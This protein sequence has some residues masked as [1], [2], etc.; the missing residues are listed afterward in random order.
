MTTSPT[1]VVGSPVNSEAGAS[2]YKPWLLFIYDW[3]VLGLF[4]TY[5]WCCCTISTSLPF[6]RDNVSRSHPDIG[7]G[8][9]YYLS[10]SSLSADVSVTL[11]DLNPSSLRVAK[12]R[13][14]RPGVQ[15]IQH[16]ILLPLDPTRKYESISMFFLLHCLPGPPSRKMALFHN[17]K[18]NLAP[19]GGN[20]R[21]HY[22]GKGGR[23]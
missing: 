21:Y 5:A 17:L 20:I 16:D 19:W 23:T 7:V 9:G 14:N 8:T 2:V 15:T 12:A 3:L 1:T 10:N 6:F 13:L 11:L 18:N 4:S 22:F